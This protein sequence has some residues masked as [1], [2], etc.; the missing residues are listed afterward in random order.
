MDGMGLGWKLNAQPHCNPHTYASRPLVYTQQAGLGGVGGG[1][2]RLRQGLSRA[3]CSSDLSD[4]R[5]RDVYEYAQNIHMDN[6]V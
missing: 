4:T 1:G 3:S 2:F 5:A 6:R